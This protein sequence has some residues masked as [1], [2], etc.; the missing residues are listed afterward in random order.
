MSSAFQFRL[1]TLIALTQ[2]CGS[3]HCASDFSFFQQ[4]HNVQISPYILL[5]VSLGYNLGY[6]I[7]YF[8]YRFQQ[9]IK[10]FKRW[11]I[12]IRKRFPFYIGL[13]LKTFSR[14]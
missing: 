13:T 4:T 5:V 9:P 7:L 2:N 11:Y 3:N 1:V 10:L 12:E 14:I 6:K 8:I